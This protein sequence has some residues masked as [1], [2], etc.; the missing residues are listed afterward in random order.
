MIIPGPEDWFYERL[1]RK[2][3]RF[4]DQD[5][6]SNISVLNLCLLKASLNHRSHSGSRFT[7]T[8]IMKKLGVDCAT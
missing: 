5:S 2:P 4:S 1:N 8:Y 7:K 3:C 6:K